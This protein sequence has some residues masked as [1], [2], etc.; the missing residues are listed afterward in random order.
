MKYQWIS[1]CVFLLTLMNLM[2]EDSLAKVYQLE[3]SSVTATRIPT[4]I[5]EA[6]GN[7]NVIT[8][9]DINLRPNTKFSD[10][11][12]GMEGIRQSKSR[13]MDTFDTATIRGI[14]NGTMIMLDGVMLNDINNNTKPIVAMN[15]DDL[16]QVEV[17]RGPFSNLYGSGALGGAINFVTAMPQ[18][19]EIKAKLGYGNPF[20]K[21]TAQENLIRGYFSIGDTFLDKKLRIKA[22][23]GFTTSSGYPAD[24]AWVYP[25]DNILNHA[26]GQ[27]PSQSANGES[28]F[29][30]GDMGKQS[31][32]THDFRL[33]FQA[34]VSDSIH[35]ES[36][37]SLNLYSYT[38]LDH[39]TYLY[40]TSTHQQIWGN[41]SN[42]VINNNQEDTSKR[43]PYPINFGRNIGQEKFLQSIVYLGYQHYFNEIMLSAKYSRIDSWDNF[44]NPDGGINM[45]NPS[46]ANTTMA[47]GD[48]SQTFT[49]HQTNNLDIFTDIPFD[50]PR[51]QAHHF[52]IGLQLRQ[53][54]LDSQINNINNW[55][56]YNSFVVGIRNKQ[57][58]K[59]LNV[60]GFME[61]RSQWLKSLS[62]TIG[63]R[64]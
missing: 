31:Y 61:Y 9:E 57:G 13:G 52:L 33:K 46:Q 24:S 16:E 60:G 45:D 4:T 18:K 58:G 5:D 22:S 54:S 36:G 42:T 43:R 55:R 59:S 41:N 14:A 48:G 62:T 23:Y 39:K 34:D 40:N 25:N 64:Y 3:T 27:I 30:I 56:D 7:V 2:A 50:I 53:T 1:F 35:I 21:D 38:H 44:N 37:G 26:S 51:T 19:F 28:I 32:N 10:T 8:K 17:I 6:P 63:M 15:A 20:Q 11:L 12:R 47:G 29:V 49:R